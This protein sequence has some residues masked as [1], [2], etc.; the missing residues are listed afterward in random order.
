MDFTIRLLIG[1]GA[2]LIVSGIGCG[3][4]YLKKR[5]HR[6]QIKSWRRAGCY[7]KAELEKTE[8]LHYGDRRKRGKARV[9]HFKAIYR[10]EAAG[11]KYDKISY[12]FGDFPSEELIYYDPEAPE[13]SFTA[14]DM[15]ADKKDRHGY[16]ISVGAGITAALLIWCLLLVW[17]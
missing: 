10:Y 14:G 5:K 13:R 1:L 2:A 12:F 7:T 4:V 8:V 16:W 17:P 6:K 3:I 9:D 15:W 11:K